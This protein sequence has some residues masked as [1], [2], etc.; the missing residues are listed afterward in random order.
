MTLNVIGWCACARILK[1]FPT[2]H[3]WTDIAQR[4]WASG[5]RGHLCCAHAGTEDVA[6]RGL[7]G[8]GGLAPREGAMTTGGSWAWEGGG[9]TRWLCWEQGG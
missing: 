3:A 8:R 7:A 5:K 6:W 4:C 2:T 1:S 9:H